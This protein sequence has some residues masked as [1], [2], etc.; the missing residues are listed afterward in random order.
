MTQ[1]VASN[2]VTGMERVPEGGG[3]QGDGGDACR[4]NASSQVL[5]VRR[6]LTTRAKTGENRQGINA[7][8]KRKSGPSVGLQNHMMVA[9]SRVSNS[10][11]SGTREGSQGL[12]DL[13]RKVPALAGICGKRKDGESG[14]IERVRWKESGM[15]ALFYFGGAV[16]IEGLRGV[17]ERARG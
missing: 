15:D 8:K 10:V 4:M 9:L 14:E 1:L 16:R 11:F 2:E 5:L 3:R 17:E 7:V 13:G 6:Y 12:R